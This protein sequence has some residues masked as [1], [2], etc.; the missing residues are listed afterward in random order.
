MVLVIV[1]IVLTAIFDSGSFSD[2]IEDNEVSTVDLIS[3]LIGAAYY[4][5]GV[6]IWSTTLGKKAMGISV[7]RPDG[8]KVSFLRAF[9]RW[10]A[11]IPSAFIL[12]IGYLMVA[13]RRDKRALHDLI[14]DTA[15]VYRR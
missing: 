9:G 11:Y 13:F 2:S 14:C 7:L 1:Q 3:L 15:V 6:S 5:L 4:T 12:F 8:S 10:L